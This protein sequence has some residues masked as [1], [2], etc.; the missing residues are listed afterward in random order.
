MKGCLVNLISFVSVHYYYYYYYYYYYKLTWVYVSRLVCFLFQKCRKV[1]NMFLQ[2]AK[3][4][5]LLF[6]SYNFCLKFFY[7]GCILRNIHE[8]ICDFAVLCSS[9]VTFEMVKLMYPVNGPESQRGMPNRKE[10]TVDPR[11]VWCSNNLKLEQ[12]IRA[13]SGFET[14]TKTRKSNKES[15]GRLL[16]LLGPDE[17]RVI[18]LPVN[19]NIPPT[20]VIDWLLYNIFYVCTIINKNFQLFKLNIL[21]LSLWYFEIST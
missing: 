5:S 2:N 16:S 3:Y 17:R 12:K 14:R 21:V 9:V 13:K 19:S 1:Q 11:P 8:Y 7:S 15:R 20:I 18:N 10:C 4:I 6:R